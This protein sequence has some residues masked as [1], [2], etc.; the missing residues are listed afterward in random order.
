MTTTALTLACAAVGNA[1]VVELD[2]AGGDLALRLHPSGA[3]LSETPTVLSVLTAAR[4][5]REQDP[6]EHHLHVLNSTTRVV[7][8]APLAEQMARAGEWPVLAE[9]LMGRD[10]PTFVD[11]GRITASSPMLA[12]ASSADLVIVVARPDIASV[13]RLRDRLV[14]LSTDLAQLSGT[15]PRL[16]PVLVTSTRHGPADVAD[17]RRVLE[18]STAKPFLVDVGYLAHDPDAVCRLEAGEDPTGRLARTNLIRS[19]RTLI[20]QV[21]LG[22]VAWT[23]TSTDSAGARP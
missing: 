18:D 11:L 6:L 13:I 7:P 17:L 16:L 21:V 22:A 2:P 10:E 5:H 15:P 3:A 14:R 19:A 20:E 8:G 23:E 12:F 1:A 9:A 4:S